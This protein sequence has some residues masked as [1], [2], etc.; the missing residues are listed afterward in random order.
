MPAKT[1]DAKEKL[2][3]IKVRRS[4]RSW[5]SK[6]PASSTARTPRPRGPNSRGPFRHPAPSSSSRTGGGWAG[7]G[8]AACHLAA[9]TTRQQRSSCGGE[10]PCQTWG[11]AAVGAIPATR[12]RRWRRLPSCSHPA[13]AP[14]HRENSRWVCLTT[15]PPLCSILLNPGGFL[16]GNYFLTDG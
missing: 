12:R 7:V 8:V 3:T 14:A 10:S 15:S 9:A 16:L 1:W 4:W 2:A 11:R 13:P 5:S 6:W